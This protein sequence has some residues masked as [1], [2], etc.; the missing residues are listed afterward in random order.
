MIV[1]S[2]ALHAIAR[3]SALRLVDSLL[4]GAVISVFA[5]LLLRARRQSAGTRFAI[6]FSALV[7]IAIMPLAGSLW[8][9]HGLSSAMTHAAFVAPESWALYLFWIWLALATISLVSVGRALWH[10]R[11]IR[12]SCLPVDLASVDA[13]LLELLR[14]PGRKVTLSTSDR[15]RVPIALGLSKPTI[16]LPGWALEELSPSE[17]HQVVLHEMT[18]LRRLDDWTNF[19][20]QI[21]K[22][23]F[24]FHP[25]VW[26]IEK[27]LA[28]EREMAC[29]DAVIAEVSSPR[30]YA[31]CLA[32]LAERSF[33]QRS[34]ALAQA[35]LGRI[36]EVSKRVSKILD[37]NRRPGHSRSWKPSAALVSGF[38]LLSAVGISQAPTLVS[39]G[40]EGQPPVSAVASSNRLKMSPMSQ[41]RAPVTMASLTESAEGPRPVLAKLSER[42]RPK[43][44]PRRRF[45]IAPAVASR[46]DSSGQLH[47]TRMET[48]AVPQAVVVVISSGESSPGQQ[49][50]QLQVWRFTVL[51]STVDPNRRPV[52]PKQT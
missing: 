27:K 24:F 46:Y 45:S 40:P 16:V 26:W 12:K 9:H 10:L 37:S 48:D 2:L 38:A 19:A 35:A 39:F 21:V 14:R 6:A 28:L 42:P 29:D 25:A 47:L 11:Q 34:L 7:A 43:F 30:A 36:S 13:G 31:E 1:P 8:P 52:P 50:Y 41:M 51:K 3:F 49:V 33:I 22:A 17:L 5:A 32:H 44:Q 23:L 18:H 20:Q 4:E 15:V